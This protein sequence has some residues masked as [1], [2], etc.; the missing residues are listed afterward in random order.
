MG[1]VTYSNRIK[2]LL[3]DVPEDILK[4]HGAVSEQAARAMAEGIRR[5]AGSNIGIGITGIA[6]PTGGT[7]EKP[8]GLVYIAMTNG[9]ETWVRKIKGTGR[10]RSRGYQRTLAASN[11]LDMV[12]RYLEGLP[13]VTISTLKP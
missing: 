8:V 2:T 13:P 9:T 7:P 3:I 4:Q 5:K 11:A 6:G 12:R 10:V 1:A